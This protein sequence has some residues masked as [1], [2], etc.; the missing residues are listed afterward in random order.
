MIT[1]L[2]FRAKG[3]A[4]NLDTKHTLMPA[5]EKRKIRHFIIKK[6][7]AGWDVYEI[8]DRLAL[9]QVKTHPASVSQVIHEY[10]QC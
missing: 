9:H 8:W 1:T 3:V 7:N 2:T 5:E 6:Y 4:M 10:Q